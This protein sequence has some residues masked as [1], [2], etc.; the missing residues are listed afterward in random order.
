MNFLWFGRNADP[1]HQPF[2]LGLQLDE[3]LSGLGFGDDRPRPSAAEGVQRLKRYGERRA[4][5][6]AKRRK[7]ITCGRVVDIADKAQRQMIVFD[8]DPARARDAT[9]HVGEIESNIGGDFEAREQTGHGSLLHAG[10]GA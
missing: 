1:A 6:L 3:R 7:N 4:A 2:L 10:E 9:A 5:D 8:I